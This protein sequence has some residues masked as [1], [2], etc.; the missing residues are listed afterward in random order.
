[1]TNDRLAPSTAAR[2]R[3]RASGLAAAFLLLLTVAAGCSAEG[4]EDT[5]RTTTTT[6]DESTTTTAERGD[7]GQVTMAPA[8]GWTDA[9]ER[10]LP[11]SVVAAYGAPEGSPGF[12]DNVNLLVEAGK[13]DDLDEYWDRSED[14]LASLPDVEE[15]EPQSDPEMDGHPAY[16]KVWT[17]R[18][19]GRQL[20]FWSVVA[21]VDGDGYVF[22]YT[23]TP[24]T[25]D[26]HRADAG[27]MLESIDIPG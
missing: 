12:Q 15:V 5:E 13:A 18:T 9:D 16:Q 8:D 6:A 3:R 27:K 10:A 24:D 19:A 11:R 22:T 26:T 2:V 7:E 25:F 20:R 21:A 4:G 1:M 14:G 17:A 23:A